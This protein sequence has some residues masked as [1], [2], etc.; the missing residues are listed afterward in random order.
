MV[1]QEDNDVYLSQLI[2]GVLLFKNRVSDKE[3]VNIISLFYNELKIYVIDEDSDYDDIYK[4]I[5]Q[6]EGGYRL[7]S[8]YN[9]DSILVK[10]GKKIR[11]YDCLRKNTTDDV[12]KFLENNIYCGCVKQESNLGYNESNFFTKKYSFFKEKLLAKKNETI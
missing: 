3:L 2:S 1:C 5:E 9:Y 7:K 12:I 10:N 6:D 8:C 11:L 4:Y